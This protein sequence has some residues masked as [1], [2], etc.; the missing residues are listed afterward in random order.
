METIDYDSDPGRTAALGSADFI[1]R[2]LDENRARRPSASAPR[3]RL[4]RAA[5]N[6]FRDVDGE[7]HLVNSF[8]RQIHRPLDPRVHSRAGHAN[9]S[10]RSSSCLRRVP[11]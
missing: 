6:G 11:A 1:A 3:S 10:S 4:S 7:V 2:E 5:E 9:D 8:N